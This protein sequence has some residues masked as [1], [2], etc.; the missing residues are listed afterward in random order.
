M[1]SGDQQKMLWAGAAVVVMAL[2]LGA[3]VFFFGDGAPAFHGAQTIPDPSALPGLSTGDA[4][5]PAELSQLKARLMAIGLPALSE[6][7]T[8]LHIHQ[9][10]DIF[11]NGKTVAVPAGIGIQEAQGFISPIHVHDE[12]GIIH[13]ESPVVADF[14]LGQFFDIWGVR[15]TA[16]CIGG[17]C[18]DDTHSLRVY[19]NGELSKGDPRDIVL[20]SHQEIVIAY[21]TDAQIPANI[22]SAFAF[23]E[24]Y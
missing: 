7:G 18:A 9:H 8:V 17:Y 20:A 1:A 6:E 22:P 12:T 21:G 11:V 23:P 16:T 4:P 15:F 24:G 13:V 2:L 10:L 19:V 14:T 3:I 5:W